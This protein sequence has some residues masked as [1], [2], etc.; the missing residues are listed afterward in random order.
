MKILKIKTN[1]DL[2][3]QARKLRYQLFFEPHALPES[4]IDDDKERSSDHFIISVRHRFAG[5][6]RL[7]RLGSNMV[8]LSQIAIH[9]SL[10]RKGYGSALLRHL[11]DQAAASET[12]QIVLSARISAQEI[13]SRQGFLTEGKKFLSSK[14]GIP[15]IKMVYTCR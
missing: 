3:L 1:S 10:Q 7:T 13:Y 12:S 2:Y 9:P 11:M 6:G 5:Y 14:T 8:Q 15:H 4:V